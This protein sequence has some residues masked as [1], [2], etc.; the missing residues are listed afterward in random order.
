MKTRSSTKKIRNLTNSISKMSV[1]GTNPN[2]K[3]MGQISRKNYK[4]II[5]NLTLKKIDAQM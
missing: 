4:K 2:L 5:G 3:G 1:G